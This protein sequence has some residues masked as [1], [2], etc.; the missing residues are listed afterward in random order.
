MNELAMPAPT[1]DELGAPPAVEPAVDVINHTRL[2]TPLGSILA[3]ANSAGIIFLEFIDDGEPTSRLRILA[4]QLGQEL[5][6]GEN[7]HI[8]QLAVELDEYF[9]G[10][11]RHFDTPLAPFGTE[12]QQ[13]VW[14][15]LLEIPYG[16]TWSYAEQARMIGAP[17]AVRAVARANGMNPI[18]IVVPCHRVIGSDG[19]LTGYAA[20]LWRKERLLRLEMGFAEGGREG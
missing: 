15:S 1:T 8:A 16:E 18:V 4:R 10:T 3:A 14:R 5:R 11:R 17:R 9:A 6:C 12:F 7:P 13:K 19:R 20:G 2:A